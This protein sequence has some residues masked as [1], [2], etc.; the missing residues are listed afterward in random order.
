MI[1]VLSLIVNDRH[2]FNLFIT[3]TFCSL[4][5]VPAGKYLRSG[6][7]SEGKLN[8]WKEERWRGGEREKGRRKEWTE[9]SCVSE[10]V[11]FHVKVMEI[12]HV[13]VGGA[14]EWCHVY[15]V[16]AVNP[17]SVEKRIGRGSVC[18]CVWECVCVGV[19]VCLCVRRHW[20]WS[21]VVICAF[22]SLFHN[23]YCV[24]E[25]GCECV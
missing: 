16:V 10:L 25:N 4:F 20:L 23:H 21:V 1:S 17:V 3:L 13:P 24:T 18:V 6:G 12:D 8:E 11:W 15:C 7:E 19:C 22:L 9:C 14:R 2:A 5:T